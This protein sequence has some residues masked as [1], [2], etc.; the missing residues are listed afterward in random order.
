[1]FTIQRHHW[2]IFSTHCYD[3]H[4]SH[5]VM[6]GWHKHN[7][8]RQHRRFSCKINKVLWLILLVSS[9]FICPCP[10]GPIY[11]IFVKLKLPPFNKFKKRTIPNQ[12]KRKQI[13]WINQM[14]WIQGYYRHDQ[15]LLRMEHQVDGQVGLRSFARQK[16]K[17]GQ[18]R[19]DQQAVWKA[20]C[21]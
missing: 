16:L 9:K 14:L 15:M 12:L 8:K 7:N 6:L 5:L 13:S 19:Q 3:H 1:M 21:L 17:L 20:I 4:C 2:W 11:K 18:V 10:S